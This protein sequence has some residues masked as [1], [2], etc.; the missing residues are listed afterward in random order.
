M[1]NQ[2]HGVLG[3]A[4]SGFFSPRTVA[5]SVS[6]GVGAGLPRRAMSGQGILAEAVD[7]GIAH[8]VE[9]IVILIVLTD[10]IHA[11]V[12]IF[13]VAA[14]T[15]RRLVRTRLLAALPLAERRTR[16]LLGALRALGRQ[17]NA[18]EIF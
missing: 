6:P 5:G 16:F 15:F 17:A 9:I 4:G 8:A 7:L 11:E 10:V 18:V 1:W 13:A 2:S 3:D 14:T 12:E